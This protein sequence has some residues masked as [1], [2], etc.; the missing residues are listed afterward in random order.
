MIL[1]A[2]ERI[3]YLSI[4]AFLIVLI[5]IPFIIANPPSDCLPPSDSNYSIQDELLYERD[6]IYIT[7]IL[8][9]QYQAGLILDLQNFGSGDRI[10]SITLFNET[11]V[12]IRGQGGAVDVYSSPEKGVRTIRTYSNFT[13]S[14]FMPSMRPNMLIVLMETIPPYS[15][16]ES[17]APEFVGDRSI[18][19]SYGEATLYYNGNVYSGLG[20]FEKNIMD[21]GFDPSGGFYAQAGWITDD[22]FIL[23]NSQILTVENS[24]IY[25]RDN[26]VMEIIDVN[27]QDFSCY[28]FIYTLDTSR[29]LITVNYDVVSYP[30]GGFC[31]GESLGLTDGGYGWALIQR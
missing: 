12:R 18:W 31:A 24:V 15:F 11:T 20:T 17:H 26:G 5:P 14:N 3:I 13:L 29:G 16:N 2:N 9:P 7:R 25:W 19:I 28:Q 1:K 6:L 27:I 30:V 21:R 10:D 8:I 22:D 23:L 4:I